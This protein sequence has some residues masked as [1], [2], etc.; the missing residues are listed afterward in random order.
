MLP[1][2]HLKA[3]KRLYFRLEDSDVNWVVTGSVSFCLQGVPVS[4]N[5][6]DIQ[7]DEAGAYELER[8]FEEY[9]VKKVKFSSTDRIRSHF[10]AIRLEGVLVEI[11]G[12]VQKYYDEEWEEPIDINRH[13]I[14]VTL[15]DMQIPV[16]NLA[17]EAEAYKRYG[18]LEMAEKLRTYANL[19]NKDNSGE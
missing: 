16:L 4:P 6:I 19:E 9:T 15:E 7:T 1:Q 18:R 14:I 11:M 13:K 12:A 2:K 8:L 17:Y 10:G 3:L 5:D